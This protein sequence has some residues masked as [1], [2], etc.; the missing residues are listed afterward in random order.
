MPRSPSP[1]ALERSSAVGL[2]G[3]VC[4]VNLGC[5]TSAHHAP[6]QLMVT[7]LFWAL[8]LLLAMQLN[9][10]VHLLFHLCVMTF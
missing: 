4:E 7:V 1:Q 5:L 6:E 9:D 2:K 3:C 10:A 8:T